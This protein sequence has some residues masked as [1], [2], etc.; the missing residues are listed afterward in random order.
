MPRVSEAVRT[1]IAR[2]SA[3]KPVVPRAPRK[4]TPQK[5]PDRLSARRLFWRRVRRSLK[6][7]LVLFVVVTLCLGV[8]SLVRML[9]TSLAM[10]RFHGFG[11][12]GDFGPR[13][14]HIEIVGAQTTDPVALRQAIGVRPGDAMLGISLKGI[15]AR[16]G[17]LGPV[18]DVTVTREFPATLRVS[19]TERNAYA[20]WQTGTAASPQFLLVDKAGNV[21][22]DQDA[23]GT[24]RRE[25]W[26]LLLTGADAPVNAAALI[27]S[28]Q[29]H[30]SVMKSVAA[31][32]R[33]AGLRWNLVLKDQSIVKL[34]EGDV[35]PA[36]AELASLEGGMQLLE[37]PVESIDLRMP[38]RLVVRPYP[39]VAMDG[40]SK[41]E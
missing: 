29:A 30:P 6:P 18:S 17:E 14:E 4:K 22:A 21:I 32:E 5:L 39:A 1:P 13:V 34:P 3:P 26:L 10:P 19:I 23:A 7:G 15:A 38:G 37:R 12:A 33:V 36:I 8:A 9:P 2:E 20:I 16:V 41:N 11:L 25:P 35:G 31:A 27:T 24:K 40:D 28:L